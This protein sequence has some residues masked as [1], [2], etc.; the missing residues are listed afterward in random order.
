VPG[1]VRW[2]LT[3]AYQV[4]RNVGVRLNIQNVMDTTY[5]DQVSAGRVTPG[6]GRTYI[7]SGNFAF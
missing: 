4:N 7:L 6:D 3:G 2:D 5:Y 1:Y